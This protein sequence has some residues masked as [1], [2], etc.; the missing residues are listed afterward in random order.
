MQKKKLVYLAIAIVVISVLL[1]YFGRPKPPRLE[2]VSPRQELSD[3]EAKYP[4][5]TKLADR[6]AKSYGLALVLVE[7][8]Y[9]DRN[10]IALEAIRSW[11]RE[12]F[13]TEPDFLHPVSLESTTE[14]RETIIDAFF[15]NLFAQG[16][17]WL[18][19]LAGQCLS[20]QIDEF[21]HTSAYRSFRNAYFDLF[22][23]D[24]D[25]AALLARY[26][27]EKAKLA[28]GVIFW[29]WL[30]IVAIVVGA[31]SLFCSK[32]RFDRLQD[33][34]VGGWLIAGISYLVIGWMDGQV[35]VFASALVCL[36][37]GMYLRFPFMLTRDEQENIKLRLITLGSNW[38][39]L[40]S[41]LTFSL[42]AVQVLTWIR[43]GTPNEPDPITL[44]LSSM[45]G[46]FLQDPALGK[47]IILRW[48][49]AVWLILGVWTA[50]QLRRDARNARELEEGLASLKGPL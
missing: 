47:R 8:P 24:A 42:V 12:R 17:Y 14:P 13:Q 48:T 29:C 38:I 41:W 27:T 7:S 19:G 2:L 10:V 23:V 18:E 43:M 34:L 33:I 49:G 3:Y 4:G 32:S 5:D 39:A 30:W 1:A 6:V 15:Y 40:A 37:I 36:A 28:V 11:A 44:L 31:I 45:T 9:T 20:Q 35:S 25:A 16:R 22:G 26:Q 21:H 50:F 46:N